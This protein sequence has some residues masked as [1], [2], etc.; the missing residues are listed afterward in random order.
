[1]ANQPNKDIVK[2]NTKDQT[3]RDTTLKWNNSGE[4]SEL[5]MARILDKLSNQELTKCDL[6]CEIE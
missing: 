6:T 5:D 4:L 1:M 3:P 2:N